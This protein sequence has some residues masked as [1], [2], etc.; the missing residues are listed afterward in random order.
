MIWGAS[1]AED[2]CGTCIDGYA[3]DA[4]GRCAESN[5][6][7]VD[8]NC[9]TAD[10]HGWCI[11]CKDGYINH[12]EGGCEQLITSPDFCQETDA[13]NQCIKCGNGYQLDGSGGC[14][15]TE[16]EEEQEVDNCTNWINGKCYGCSPGYV[17]VQDASF[18]KVGCKL[19]AQC[20]AINNGLCM[21]CP[22]KMQKSEESEDCVEPTPNHE[23]HCAHQ[24]LD[25]NKC[26]FCES[27]YVQD[28]FSGPCGAAD[29]LIDGCKIQRTNGKCKECFTG[30]DLDQDTGYKACK[31]TQ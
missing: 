17:F 18:N 7:P 16:E 23:Y 22:N 26:I 19:P 21:R 3:L 30:F 12:S 31:P 9:T 20:M 4:T 11:E 28:S 25:A 27:G 14:I 29:V 5:T 15:I 24:N 1:E 6:R 8:D 13:T 2:T 10:A